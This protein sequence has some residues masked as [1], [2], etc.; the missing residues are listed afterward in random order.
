MLAE[1]TGVDLNC[2]RSFPSWGRGTLDKMAATQMLYVHFPATDGR[3]LILTT[4]RR[5]KP[6]LRQPRPPPT[7]PA[8][9]A[10]HCGNNAARRPIRTNLVVETHE[11]QS[12]TLQLFQA[13][14]RPSWESRANDTPNEAIPLLYGS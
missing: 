11:L 13:P 3:T 1:V 12:L 4:E 9:A 8:P 2:E 5:K 7:F 6:L 14:H 10:H